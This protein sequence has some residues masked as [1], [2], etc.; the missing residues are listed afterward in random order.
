MLGRKNYTR[1][2]FHGA[3]T[4]IDRQLEAYRQLEAAVDATGDA[5]ARSALEDFEPIFCNSM[6]LALDRYFV[7]RVRLV[8]G[9]DGNPL[10]EVELLGESLIGNDGVL[11]SSKVIK[12]VPEESVTKLHAG[13]RIA[14]TAAEFEQLATAFFAE[15]E[16]R[17]VAVPA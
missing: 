9:N 7:H 12:L 13:D 3:R 11:L 16:R 5:D 14:L 1:E 10:N 6:A 15:L 2:E 4:A 17:F 8:T